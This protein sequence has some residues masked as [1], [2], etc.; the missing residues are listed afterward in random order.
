MADPEMHL[1]LGAKAALSG[2][3]SAKAIVIVNVTRRYIWLMK[4][5]TIWAVIRAK[6]P[7]NPDESQN[8]QP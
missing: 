3:M 1:T 4:M 8:A 5:R 6:R 2:K 7:A